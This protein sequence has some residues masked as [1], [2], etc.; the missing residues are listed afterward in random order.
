MVFQQL[1]F[2]LP[3][4]QAQFISSTIEIDRLNSSSQSLKVEQALRKL[5]FVKV[6]KMDLNE[7]S[8]Q[9]TFNEGSDVS[10]SQLVKKI[11]QSGFCVK[12]VSANYFF[13]TSKVVVYDTIMLNHEIYCFLKMPAEPL[14]KEVSF[15]FFGEKYQDKE[16]YLEWKSQIEAAKQKCSSIKSEM[17]FVLL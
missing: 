3:S 17:Y 11:K 14:V 1:I 16:T 6:V 7:A 5:D 10:I 4:V 12:S 15:R 8:A 2:Q 13:Q 9:I